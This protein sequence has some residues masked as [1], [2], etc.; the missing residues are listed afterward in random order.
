MSTI[1]KQ[2]YMVEKY[3]RK[4]DKEKG[5]NVVS[6]PIFR[7]TSLGGFVYV[8]AMSKILNRSTY[9]TTPYFSRIGITNSI[10]NS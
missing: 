9:L 5:I 2:Y 4:R 8:F 6:I 1:S 10:G 7:A 3:S